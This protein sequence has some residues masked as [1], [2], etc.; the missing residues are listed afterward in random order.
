MR[1]DIT[2]AMDIPTG[3]RITII[4]VL[5]LIVIS[6]LHYGLNFQ[7][8]TRPVL[9][10]GYMPVITNLAC[11][12]LDFASKSGTG[13]RFEALKFASFAEMG[14]ALRNGGIQ[15]AFIIAP[16]AV[17]L[18]QQGTGVKIVYIGNRHESTLVYRKDL[19]VRSFSDLAGKTIAVPMRYSGHNLAARQL[20]DKYGVT[21]SDLNIVEMN[22]PDMASALVVGSL[23]A[24]FVGEP[25]AAQTVK[26]GD[27]KVL[28]YVS[29]VWPGFICNL[30]LVTQSYIDKYPD[31][32][33]LLVQGAARSGFWAQEHPRE[34]AKIAA[35]YWNQPLALVEWT[36]THPPK[37]FVFDRFVPKQEEIQ[38]LAD[39]M[40]RFDLLKSADIK[41][42]IDDRFAK[43][44]N[45][46]GITD[47]KSILHVPER[48]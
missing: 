6:L 20:G 43:E 22:P 5:W 30:V 31:R 44:A 29:E 35:N 4:A 17:V 46:E 39:Q 42:L 21:G 37:R 28:H 45:L 15:A 47:L 14:E 12:L 9:R 19:N 26:G 11:P 27:S 18:H 2:R 3:V 25:F 32:V 41:G 10:M 48:K 7:H 36:M 1:F 13:L 33:R 34:A 16:L 8:G 24:Y 23:D 40:V 38:Y